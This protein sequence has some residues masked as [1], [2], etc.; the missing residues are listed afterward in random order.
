MRLITLTLIFALGVVVLSSCEK[1]ITLTKNASSDYRIIIPSNATKSELKAASYLQRYIE[2][3]GGAR[4]S[5]VRDKDKS[6]GPEISMGNTNRL[7]ELGLKKEDNLVSDGFNIQVHDGDLFF[8]GGSDKAVIYAASSFMERFL[9]VQVLSSKVQIFDQKRKIAIPEDLNWT[10]N[11]PFDF[12]STHY[13]D[14]WDPFFAD[15]HKLHHLPNGGHPDWGYWCHSFDQLVP[16]SEYYETHPEYYAEINGNRVPTQLCLTNPE[17]LQITIRNLRKAID[18]KPDLKYWSVSQNDNVSYCHC[19]NCQ[20]LDAENESPMGS[21]LTFVNA[22]ADSFPDHVISTLSYQYSRKPPTRIVP[23]DNVNIMLCT[24]ELNRSEPIATS[25]DAASFRSDLEGWGKICDDILLWDYLV[26]FQNLVSPFPN[27]HVIQPNLEYFLDNNAIKHFQQANREVGGEFAELR[28]FLI[29]KLLWEPH[30]DIDSLETIFLEGYY[31]K[32]AP[33]IRKYIDLQQDELIKSGTRLDIF[34]HPIHAIN[35]Y[36]TSELMTEYNRLFDMAEKRVKDDEEILTRVWQARMPLQYAEIE[37]ATRL[38]TAEGGMYERDSEGK[39]KVREDLKIL[40][41]TLVTRANRQGVT[42]FKEWNTTPDEYLAGLKKSWS[43]DMQDHLAMNL[44]PELLQPAS[45]KYAGGNAGVM[46]D[47]LRG[48]A[49]TY[50]Y[51]W[52]GFEGNE[53]EVI[54]DLKKETEISELNSSWLHDNRSWIFRPDGIK[55]FGSNDKSQWVLIGEV[56]ADLDVRSPNV[57]V[58]DLRLNLDKTQSFRYVKFLTSSLVDCPDWHHGAGG[59]A[60]IFTDELIV[61]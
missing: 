10:Y 22:V 34:G 23:R 47:G 48:P 56:S 58:I 6:I 41:D 13:R 35:T 7:A 20:K 52:L 30:A 39:W 43:V 8:T 57:E 59:P 14:T 26:Q 60:W 3:V 33:L 2:N 15:W 55:Y 24:I 46:T 53:C 25:D 4:M 28:G 51:N 1:E 19:E 44:E 36:L 29:S 18:E 32:A 31:G 9:G 11:P 17:V 54:I 16:P 61:K 21:L 50:A 37:I 12:R 5:I 38:G 42:R 49:L 27:F 40:A 45:A